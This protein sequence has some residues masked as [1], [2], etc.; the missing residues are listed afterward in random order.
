M[1]TVTRPQMHGA[2]RDLVDGVREWRL[3]H[4]L[5]WQ[6]IK[7][8][9]RRSIL[10]TWWLVLSMLLQVLTMGF[11]MS[12]LFNLSVEKHLPY[13]AAGMII[14]TGFINGM[15]QEGSSTYINSASYILQIRRPSSVYICKMLWS[16]LIRTAHYLAIYILFA[17]IYS[18]SPTISTLWLLLSLPL[19]LLSVSWLALFLG[20]LSAR[21]RD[22]P[23][24]LGSILGVLFWLTPIL[25]RADMLGDKRFIVDLNPFSHV[26]EILRAPLMGASPAPVSWIVVAGFATAGWVV[27]LLFFARFRARIPYWL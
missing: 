16:N 13:L 8:G 20:I 4:L 24:M 7:G 1:F 6:E 17:I 3:W 19:A 12:F 2:I 27:T 14:W 21:F 10:G 26:L 18:V 23:V 22:V 25:Y 9:Y 5:A 11:V 15:L